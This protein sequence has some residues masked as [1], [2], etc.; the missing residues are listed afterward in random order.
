MV[1]NF[2]LTNFMQQFKDGARPNQFAVELALP[3]AL[4][5][6]IPNGSQAEN[7]F[8]F[9]CKASEI[10]SSDIG[11]VSIPFRGATVKVAG[12]RSFNDWTVTLVNDTDFIIRD[13]IEFWSDSISGHVNRDRLEVLDGLS[14][15]MSSGI[16]Y[17]L[18]RNN[19]VLKA[20]S[21]VGIWPKSIAQIGLDFSSNDQIEEF[22]VT[23]AVQWWEARTTRNNTN[24]DLLSGFSGLLI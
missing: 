21:I 6:V 13:A 10:P 11:E 24:G 23:F 9:L 17:Q 2:Q 7:K 18:D 15:Y 1:D 19:R 8:R 3:V 4:Q 20:Y 12:D 5:G 16:V 14:D 22:Q